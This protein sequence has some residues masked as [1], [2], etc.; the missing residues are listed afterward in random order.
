M[1]IFCNKH[2]LSPSVKAG[3]YGTGGWAINGDIVIDLSQI[4]D[5]DIEPPQPGGGYTSL[6]DTA[7]SMSKGKAPVGEPVL[8]TSGPGPATQKQVLQSDDAAEQAASNEPVP[9]AWLYC[10]ASTAVAS[11][12]HGPALP[13]DEYGEQPRRMPVS[14][15][16]SLTIDGTSSVT[17][18]LLSHS[19]ASLI[20][21]GGS[22]SGT[23]TSVGSSSRSPWS[24]F[25]T[26]S[27][28]S[29]SPLSDAAP[30]SASAPFSWA[31]IETGPVGSDPFAYIDNAEQPIHAM[32]PPSPL[33]SR[34]AAWGEDVALLSHPLFAGEGDVP[35]HLTRPVPPHTHAYVSFGAGVK[36]KDVD[37]FTAAHP[38]GDSN[39]PYHVPLCVYL[40]WHPSLLPCGIL[41]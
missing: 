12:L 31:D 38:L 29:H 24:A 21:S 18:S 17:E 20:T 3:G 27:A 19:E 7:S 11:L 13:L 33:S 39:V 37:S 22:G 9:I 32:P 41:I 16:P 26:T 8:D 4:Q 6:R 28:S 10:T 30:S 36:Q 2:G 23:L 1:I 34:V 5:I 15:P 35:P 25:A 40:F 14:G